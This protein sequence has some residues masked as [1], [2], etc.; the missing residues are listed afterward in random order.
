MV[1]EKKAFK[2]EVVDVFFGKESVYILALLVI[3]GLGKAESAFSP[4][5]VGEKSFWSCTSASIQLK[6]N[7][8]FNQLVNNAS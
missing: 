7:K 8:R 5:K 2:Q 4:Q 3:N 1:P 6:K